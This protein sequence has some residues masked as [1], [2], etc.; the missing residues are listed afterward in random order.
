MIKTYMK[1]RAIK[2]KAI[3]VRV[4][5]KKPIVAIRPEVDKDFLKYIKV[6]RAWVRHKHGLSIEDFE[7]LCY[8]YSEHVF[9]NHQF[10]QYAQIFGF[11]QD[12]K[13]D[14]MEKGLIIHFRKPK[15]GQ[16]AIFELSYKAKSLMKQVYEML[17]GEREIPKLSDI[18]PINNRP[19]HFAKRQ[20]DRVIE[21]ANK[22]F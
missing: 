15:P 9:D 20:Y 22:N 21:R 12:R 4:Y 5:K 18:K 19:H 3:K 1:P 17:Q 11:T 7:M 8:L 2:S 6:V 13:R 16:R 14:L 10:D